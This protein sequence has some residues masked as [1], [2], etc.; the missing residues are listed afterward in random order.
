M[1]C[2]YE[3]AVRDAEREVNALVA[4]GGI[5]EDVASLLLAI[6]ESPNAGYGHTLYYQ[7]YAG[8][9]L[10]EIVRSQLDKARTA[11]ASVLSSWNGTVLRIEPG[12]NP[13]TVMRA[14]IRKIRASKRARR[15]L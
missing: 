13:E 2:N 6:L 3:L 5:P 1:A 12:D 10:R 7:P 15:G 8:Q 14:F 11:Y 4:H 9:L